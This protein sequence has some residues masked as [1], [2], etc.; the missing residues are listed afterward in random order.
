[1]RYMLTGDHWD[2]E[3]AY[4]IGEVQQVAPNPEEAL[5]AGIQIANNI[6]ACGPLGI[7]TTLISAHLAVDPGK[8]KH[9][10]SSRRNLEPLSIRR[11][12]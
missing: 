3:E 2:A 1:M 9:C 10:Q 4:R 7:K 12:F 5:K 6:A 11:T 8:R